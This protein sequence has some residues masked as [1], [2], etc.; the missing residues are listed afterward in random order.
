MRV[1]L[2]SQPQPAASTTQV[3]PLH[4][5][6]AQGQGRHAQRGLVRRRPRRAS[7]AAATAAR[8]PAPPAGPPTAAPPRDSAAGA[9]PA[10]S[11]TSWRR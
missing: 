1:A 6:R 2:P 5:H 10:R 3:A 4:P 9:P 8:Y 11:S 7:A